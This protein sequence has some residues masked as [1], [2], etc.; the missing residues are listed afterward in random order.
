[1]SYNFL[2][3]KQIILPLIIL[4]GLFVLFQSLKTNQVIEIKADQL[5][6]QNEISILTQ[7]CYLP[8]FLDK[9]QRLDVLSKKIIKDKPDA[10]FLQEIL[11]S[12]EL[13]PLKNDYQVYYQRG[14]LGPK[15]GLAIATKEK[16]NDI[17]FY[18][19]KNQGTI[20]SE[21]R[22]DRIIEKGVLVVRFSDA[23]LLNTHL[24]SIYDDKNDNEAKNNL[25]QFNQLKEIIQAEK[26]SGKTIV[27][28]GD[29]NFNNESEQY[30]ELTNL[31][32]DQTTSLRETAYLNNQAQQ[33]DFI[34]T[35]EG[36]SSK[37]FINE[38]E[39][40]VSD[41]YGIVTKIIFD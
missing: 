31:L 22:N 29:F 37:T 40:F 18:K 32:D 19:F 11:F 2:N 38:Y 39:S 5:I 41:H 6:T 8:K 3:K 35:N 7:N 36:R 10:V 9:W 16:T 21:Q 26:K 27:L 33:I 20:F 24:V 13:K 14:R 12:S 1:M 17:S 30:K 25:E 34:L 28:A 23:I 15:G 4:I